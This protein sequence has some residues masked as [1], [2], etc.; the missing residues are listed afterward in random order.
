[1]I[2]ANELRRGNWILFDKEPDIVTDIS[3]NM[4]GGRSFYRFYL[5]RID[6]IPL[7][8]EILEACGFES[9]GEGFLSGDFGQPMYF[10]MKVFIIYGKIKWLINRTSAVEITSLHQFQNL[11]FALTGTELKYSPNL[12]TVS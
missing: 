7:T 12:K 11:Y 6:P 4:I 2:K 8:P 10:R 9:D 1:M 5:D 3:E